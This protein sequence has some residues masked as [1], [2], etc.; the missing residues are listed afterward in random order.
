MDPIE[1]SD[2]PHMCQFVFDMYN[3]EMDKYMSKLAKERQSKPISAE[4]DV[5]TKV[6][7]PFKDA[8]KVGAPY[9]DGGK[10][11]GLAPN[12]AEE[13]KKFVADIEFEVFE[14]E[15]PRPPAAA[16]NGQSS[17]ERME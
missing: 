12:L 3:H 7:A 9:K 5:A 10:V 14:E 6:V 13:E 2:M 17:D 15:A 1:I 4:D 11:E 8:A 16:V